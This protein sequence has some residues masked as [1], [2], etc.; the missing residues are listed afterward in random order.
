[1]ALLCA[2][3]QSRVAFEAATCS[4]SRMVDV[5]WFKVGTGLWKT[6]KVSA[7][8]GG[9][10]AYSACRPCLPCVVGEVDKAALLA[11]RRMSSGTLRSSLL[12]STAAPTWWGA[13]WQRAWTRT[14]TCAQA[15]RL[16]DHYC[17]QPQRPGGD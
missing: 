7:L 4:D 15:S 12:S 17:S 5:P 2:L 8:P 9:V 16:S 1:M 13:S 14:D 10:R 6:D 11:R 3:L